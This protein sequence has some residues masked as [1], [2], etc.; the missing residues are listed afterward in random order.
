MV[1]NRAFPEVR[2]RFH[3][4]LYYDLQTNWIPDNFLRLQSS[5]I[6]DGAVAQLVRVPDCRSGGCGF[7]SRLRRLARLELWFR[8]GFFY[9]PIMPRLSSIWGV[10][11][12]SP[13][14]ESIWGVNLGSQFGES[15]WGVNLVTPK[16][17]HGL[18]LQSVI[19]SARRL[20]RC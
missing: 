8:L 15:I 7:E 6:V 3:R 20:R 12:G 18:S 14:G 17:T 2:D 5:Q 13:F 16:V 1:G 11:L 10:H 4:K 9:A 19:Q